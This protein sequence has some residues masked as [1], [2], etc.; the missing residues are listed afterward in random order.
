VGIG[1]GAVV[2]EA[3]GRRVGPDEPVGL[4]LTLETSMGCAHVTHTLPPARP[5]PVDGRAEAACRETRL[6]LL[7]AMR[8]GVAVDEVVSA[9][10]AIL[11]GHD[12]LGYKEYDFGH[13]TGLETPEIPRLIEG[14]G[15]VLEPGMTIS[16]HVSVRRPGGETAFVGGPIV[17]EAGG[18]REL[19]PTAP[20]VGGPGR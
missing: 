15:E 5:R 1:D 6:G 2:T 12:L 9:G 16:V 19:D 17:V 20:W 10:N 8:P 14:T 11:A 3:T 13:G 7:R 4:E 18:P